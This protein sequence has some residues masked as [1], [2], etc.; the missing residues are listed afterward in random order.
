MSLPFQEVPEGF[1]FLLPGDPALDLV[2]VDQ[3]QQLPQGEIK[4]LV[5]GQADVQAI[6]L[7]PGRIGWTG[8]AYPF[9]LS[10]ASALISGSLLAVMAS[11]AF[12]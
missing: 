4:R 12:R 1:L 7:K 2:D 9:F 8:P 6:P 3:R 10:T 5:V 11:M